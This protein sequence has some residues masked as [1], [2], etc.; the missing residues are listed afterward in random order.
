MKQ[1]SSAAV[2][3]IKRA[4]RLILNALDVSSENENG[5]DR[6]AREH[7]NGTADVC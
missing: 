5:E 7:F 2:G 6:N 3:I 4:V 1:K